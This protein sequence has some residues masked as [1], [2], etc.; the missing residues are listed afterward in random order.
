MLSVKEGGLL[1]SI[2]KILT[3]HTVMMQLRKEHATV[4]RELSYPSNGIT[5]HVIACPLYCL[6]ALQVLSQ[7]TRQGFKAVVLVLRYL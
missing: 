6:L 4:T 7:I 1:P 5:G 2:S 3:F